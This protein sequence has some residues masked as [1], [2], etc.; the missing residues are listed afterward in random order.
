MCEPKAKGSC[1]SHATELLVDYLQL[2]PCVVA[3]ITMHIN[4]KY[5][6]SLSQ[7]LVDLVFLMTVGTTYETKIYGYCCI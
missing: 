2:P 3:E 4:F 5:M 1:V 6:L 7:I